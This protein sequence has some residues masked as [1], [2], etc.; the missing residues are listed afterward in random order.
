[1]SE[2]R[3]YIGSHHIDAAFVSVT[4]LERKDI[5]ASDVTSANLLMVGDQSNNALWA[6]SGEDLLYGGIGDDELHGGDGSDRIYGDAGADYLDGDG[7][8][9][10]LYGGTENDHLSGGSGMDAL[11]GEAGDDNLNGGD[12]AD[13]LLGGAGNDELYGGI[14][15]DLL[16]AEIGDGQDSLD[17]GL[18]FSPSLGSLD[19]TDTVVYRYFSGDATIRITQP[20]G[21]A[22][23]MGDFGLVI[24]PE[25]RGANGESGGFGN[26]SLSSIE[27]AAVHAGNGAD[28]LKLD[29]DS[30]VDSINYVDLGTQGDNQYDTIDFTLRTDDVTVILSANT[31]SYRTHGFLETLFGTN[32]HSLK[33]LN[34]EAVLGGS[35]NDTI[36]GNAAG[37]HIK[38]N[39]G[40]D[41]IRGGP[42]AG[43]AADTYSLQYTDILEGG[44]G[45]DRITGGGDYNIIRGDDGNDVLIAA[46]REGHLYGGAGND[47]FKVGSN[48]WIEET[49]GRDTVSYGGIT[50]YGGV[51]QWWMEGNKAFW[52]PMTTVM[53]A[54]PVIGSELLYTASFFIDVQTMKFATYTRAADGTLMMNLGWGHGG[55]AAIRDYHLDL[56]TGVGS[57]GLAVFEASHGGGS[58]AGPSS[59]AR[60]EKFVNLALKAGFGRG[61]SGFDPLVIDLD[62]DGYE[63]TTQGNSSTYFEFDSDGFGER[64]GWMRGDDG[65]LVR[66]SN[67]NG[68][69]DDVTEMFGNASTSGFAMLSGF[70]LNADGIIDPQDAI[71]AELKVWQDRDMDGV[72]DPGELKTLAE[73]GI[74]SI[75]LAATAPADPSFIG[76]NRLVDSGHF[77]WADG[78]TGNLADFA[79]D[80]NETA[81]RWLGDSTVGAAAAALPQLKGK[82][83]IK[84]LRVAMTGDPALQASVA[85]F[86]AT[87]TND[88]PTLKAGAESILYQWAGVEGVAATAIG[89]NGFDSRKLAF[90]EKYSGYQLMPRDSNG[91]VLTTNLAEMETLWADEV[92]RLTLRLVVQGPMADDFDGISYR[93]DLDLLV[94]DTPTA[95]GDLYRALLEDLPSDPA[96]ALAQWQSWAPLLG[97]MAEGMRRFDSNMVRGD[98]VAAQIAAAMDG[99]AQPLSFAQLAGAL[100]IDNIRTGTAGND[101]LARAGASGTAVYLA[102]GGGTDSLTGGSGQDVYIFGRTIGHATINDNEPKP[103]GDRI[104]FAFLTPDEVSLRRDG[105]DLLITVK[106]TG[107][108]VRV[109]GQ[110]A[111]VVP[112][113]SDTL[114]SSNKGVE[115]IQF[116]DGTIY[117]IPEI[118]TAVGTGTDGDDHIVG[119]MHSDVLIGGKGNDRLEGGDDADLYVIR[120]GDGQDVISDH[121]S[122]VLLRAADLLIFGNGIAPGELVFSRT[123]DKGDDL[124][125]TIGAAGQT[126]LIEDQFAYSS[127]GYNHMWSPNSRI[128]SFAFSDYGDSFG[129][130]DLEVR[131]IAESTTSGNDVTRGFGDDD[132]FYSSA[133]NDLLI[134][135]DG[136]DGYVWGKGSGNDTIDED[137]RYIGTNVALGGITLVDGNDTVLFGPGIVLSDLVFSRASAAPDLTVTLVATGETLTVVN[138][139][140]G[141]QTGPLGAQWFDR[142]EWFQFADGSRISWQQVLAD[143]TTG[144]S[145]NDSLWGDLHADVMDGGAG[146]DILSGLGLGDTYVFK[147]G[148]GHDT[149]VD[150]NQAI[151]GS[152]FITLDSSPDV[153]S[154]GP[155]IAPADISFERDGKSLT[156]IVGSSGDRVTL[157]GQNDYFHTGVFGAISYNR[158]EEI[159]FEDGTVWTWQELNAKVLAYYTTPG[160]DV[161]EGFMTPDRFEAS[162]GDDVLIGGDSSDTYAFGPGSGHDTVRESVSNIF[163]GDEDAIEFA[164]GILPAGVG[165]ARDGEDL[166][167]T[168]LA[169]GDTLTIDGEF[170]YSNWFEWWD[171]ERFVFTDGTVWTK[172]DLQVRLL[173]PT[174]GDDHMIGFMTSDTL[175][176]G[177]GNDILEGGDG[178]DTYHFGLGSGHDVIQE[179]VSNANLAESDRLVFGAGI[180]PSDVSFARDGEALVITLLASGETV[181]IDWQFSFR[182][183]FAWWDIELFEFADGTVLSDRDVARLVTGGTPGDDHILGTFRSD[184]LDGG[185]GNDLLEGGDGADRYIFGRGYGQD[186]IR[187]G[188]SNAN[189]SEDD[190][191]QFLPGV[192]LA[193]L[194]FE[195]S[196][197]DLVITILGTTDSLKITDQFRYSSWFTWWDVD[198]FLFDDGSALTKV[199]IQQMLL[200]PTAG[201]DHIVGFMTGDTI[202]GGAGND[203]LQGEDGPDTYL[204]GRGSGQDT[205]WETLH[206]AN[207]SEYDTLR[208]GADIA[209][210]D[211]RFA[212]SGDS[213]TISIAG[214]ADSITIAEQ[215]RTINPVSAATW[216]DVENFL[217]ADGTAR[218]IADIMAEFV[219]GTA[220]DDHL[221]G[222][223][224][225]D[226][227]VGGVG[228]DVMEGARGADTY[229]H[230]IGD[231]HDVVSDYVDY[232]GSGGDRIVFGA[233][234]APADVIVRRSAARPTDMVLV[235]RGGESSVTLTNQLAGLRDWTIDSVVFADGTSW[236]E[237]DLANKVMSGVATPGDDVIPGTSFADIIDGGAGDDVV[238]SADGDDVLTG[239]EGND[240]LHSGEGNDSLDGGAGADNLNGAIGNDVL[241]GGTGDDILS[242]GGASDLYKFAA[243]D[244]HDVVREFTTGGDGWGGTDT[245]EFGEGIAPADL[246]VATADF[247]SDLVLTVAATG[248]SVTLDGDVT[249]SDFRIEQ[250]R[251]FDGTVWTHA[252]L[253]SMALAATAGADALRG[254]YDAETISGAAGDDTID[255]RQGNDVL[256]GGTGNDLLIGSGGD[257]IYRFSPGDGDDIVREY[258]S[259]FNGWGGNDT[260]EFGAGIVPASVIV[261]QADSG[262]DLVLII[263]GTADRVTVDGGLGGGSNYRVEQVRFADGTVWAWSDLVARSTGGTPGNDSLAGDGNANTISGGAGN[264]VIEGRQGDD[265]LA[266][267]TGND[268]LYGSAG[269]DTYVFARG[270]GGDSIY[271]FS[272]ATN[273]SGGN[274]TIEFG[275]GILP[276]DV[277]VTEA[278]WGWD[279]VLSIAGTTDSITIDSDIQDGKYRIERVVFANG[280]I[281]THADLMAKATVSTA[282]DDVLRGSYDAETISAGAGSDV[283]DGRDGNDVIIGGAGNDT[284]YGSGGDDIYIYARGD[285]FDTIREFIDTWSGRGGNDRVQFA[286]G[287][288]AADITIGKADSGG[289]YV[290]YVDG[291]TG[292][293]T[294]TGGATW[295]SDYYVETVRFDDGTSWNVQELEVRVVAAS[296]AADTLNGDSGANTLRGLG[297]NDRLVGGE[298]AD[299]L[300]GDGGDDVLVGDLAGFD[301][302]ASGASLLVNGGFEQAGTIISTGSWGNWNSTMPGWTRLNSQNYEQVKSGEGGIWASEGGYWLDLEGG[303]GSGSNM[304]ISQTIS[305]RA[306]GQPLILQFDHSSRVNSPSGA[307]E[308]WWNNVLVTTVNATGK[309]MVTD[310]LEL[311]AVA[312][313]NVLTFKG[314]GATDSVG[315]SLDNVRLF[316]TVPAAAGAD[317]LDGGDGNDLID[318]GAG[319]DIL[320]GGAGAD[321]FRF[322]SGDTGLGSAADRITDFLSGSDRIDLSAIDANSAL[323]GDQAFA[324]ITTAAFTGSAGQL[325]YSGDGTDTWLE[326]DVDGDGAADFQI[327]LSGSV[328]LL[329]TDFTL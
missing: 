313:D 27:K 62:G 163:Y 20:T 128:E 109:T 89:A 261:S 301:A 156:L 318:G 85:A 94:A 107:E 40:N 71:Y 305:G 186:E 5:D 66:D 310:R 99:I 167:L 247:G 183:W 203:I 129:I 265:I 299:L 86:A 22:A 314:I 190:E 78:R 135:M 122:T 162:A 196:G 208:F 264:D 303:G 154:F 327:V 65:F 33:V 103:A 246:I 232:W 326:A 52:A 137:A 50:V 178:S 239:G 34:A 117:E 83:E 116:A 194:G 235:V 98:Y 282:G 142:I 53:A 280:T 251:F 276:G 7:G 263:A 185:A 70:D 179:T 325:R 149:L 4:D 28:T 308:V 152:G 30:N 95:L 172:Q 75:A 36:T 312:G 58:S 2:G 148:Y 12:D 14:G 133:G 42:S 243:G 136:V 217:F 84:D 13:V 112:M 106:A 48:T 249:S 39:A 61:M 10:F 93:A 296:N 73:L 176:G 38:G 173:Q 294:L 151:M 236:T 121:Q 67:G 286:P 174:A 198:R 143:V 64:T 114:L 277:I 159:R 289:S 304:V 323:P 169:T 262:S 242:G 268:I 270:D 6:G 241:V 57:A 221:I 258:S 269:N 250:V 108:T 306:A 125:V 74:V 290:L 88:L 315:A 110:F 100:G 274:D 32:V 316:A 41:I 230:N 272:H 147:L 140:A 180:L 91:A 212:R 63:M 177:A 97:A 291:G 69:I 252:Q 209:W 205:I 320:T 134:G 170:R 8:A 192:T 25:A 256:I 51:K 322:E 54:F 118:M 298:G 245:I 311:V 328:A 266:G 15:D 222:Y 111:D 220:G 113:G 292:S 101:A 104:R 49:L 146:T 166:I 168:L 3:N 228:N 59:M 283:V 139:F 188:L 238:T 215:F 244:G 240:I 226:T 202:D 164:A 260:I 218:T 297:G 24:G 319:A 302:V 35:G 191:L 26:D 214:T 234:I 309:T 210:S 184:V 126:V 231:G 11:N 9:D 37:N 287:I 77:T 181:R 123:G 115:D 60:I 160:N 79:L 255:G 307:F 197:N 68:K 273:G 171:V 211:L 275:E 16:I 253:M 150:N 165:V 72:T 237:Q 195:R 80:I 199:D 46:G 153:L 216:W 130:K 300:K 233:G 120:A 324:F 223:Y 257:D 81:T 119:T 144:T 295:G 201:D 271:E 17:G 278:D 131:L 161:A 279:L 92:T 31:L 267:G 193:D 124:L 45:D 155:G 329:P 182:N 105:F 213:L 1:M 224:G 21:N 127:L 254:S 259:G 229:I 19:G 157:Q 200:A 56:D 187:E 288:L 87:T 321:L 248:Q 225:A 175:D 206:N 207:L 47:T 189:L 317:L 138:Q 281:W 141:F 18:P 44:A 102:E 43:T 284:L 23:G 132:I 76:G 29:D 55:T 145:G 90:L 219:K 82:G 204:F 96:A 158:I 293:I 285:G 227:F